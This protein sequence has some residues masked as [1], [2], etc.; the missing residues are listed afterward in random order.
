MIKSNLSII[1]SLLYRLLK[2]ML[3]DT[4]GREI[5]FRK[6]FSPK[7]INK[8]TVYISSTIF[9]Q[10]VDFRIEGKS[11]SFLNNASKYSIQ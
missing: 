1:F 5:V 8:K 2:I 11:K 4:G 10:I 6:V 3:L 7:K 9:G